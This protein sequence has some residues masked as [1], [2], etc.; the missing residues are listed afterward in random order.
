MALNNFIQDV[1]IANVLSNMEKNHVFAKD[2]R[3]DF[4]GQ[5]LN[6]N[7]KVTFPQVTDPTLK[8]YIKDS[9]IAAPD[10]QKDAVTELVVDQPYY[11]NVAVDDL[12]ANQANILSILQ[13]KAG[14][15]INDS[16]DVY[17]AGLY[18]QCGL[19]YKTSASPEDVN[20]A[21]AED[22]LAGVAETMDEANVPKQGRFGKIPPWFYY[23]LWLAGLTTKTQNDVMY[24]NGVVGNILGID[25]QVSNNISK[26]SASWDI[27]RMVFGV[28][29]ES[30]GHALKIK[31][32]ETYRPDSYMADAVKGVIFYGAKILR[33]DLTLVAYADKTNES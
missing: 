26:N 1:F 13:N 22:F 21:N 33:P 7:D 5:I 8:S 25:L 32:V 9:A 30:F 2:S 12:E 18:A 28:K 6:L 10:F 27:T 16:L 14:Y 15:K 29:N 3:T 31:K 24:E 19:A 17:M 23:K 4:S 11:F 20:S